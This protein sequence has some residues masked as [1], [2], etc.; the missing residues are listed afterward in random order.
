[1]EDTNIVYIFGDSHCVIFLDAES[2]KFKANVAGYDGASITG[3]NEKKSRLE[4]GQHITHIVNYAPRTNYMLMKLGQVDLEFI[5]YH[6]AYIKRDIFTFKEFCDG[7][8]TKYGDFIKKILEINK[9]VIIA[10]I[11]LPSYRESVDIKGYIKRIISYDSINNKDISE[12]VDMNKIN[13]T[14]PALCNITIE[15]LTKNFS[16]FNTLLCGL[17]NELKLP[18]FDTTSL[19]IDINTDMLKTVF[20]D[21]G[22]HYKG[23]NDNTQ[24]D[25]KVVTLDILFDYLLE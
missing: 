11:N 6:K 25:A 15:Q 9:N 17:A 12:S 24:S 18:F 4:Y 13:T 21:N 3:L 16:Y 2:K 8:I 20:Q 19:F 10:S 7:L 23:Y 14:D 1:M 22:H 5:M